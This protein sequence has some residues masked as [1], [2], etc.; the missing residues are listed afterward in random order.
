VRL[1]LTPTG[2][3]SLIAGILRFSCAYLKW[4]NLSQACVILSVI[5][6]T[7]KETRIFLGLVNLVRTI[8]LSQGCGS[9]FSVFVDPDPYWES[10]S[11]IRI[12][13]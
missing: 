9:G 2:T 4:V 6:F 1:A 13:G 10:G 3:N 11:R 7:Q 12:H 5:Y 8:P